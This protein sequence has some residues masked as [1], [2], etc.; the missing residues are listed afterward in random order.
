MKR[1]SVKTKLTAGILAGLACTATSVCFAQDFRA[2][3]IWKRET[4]TH[5]YGGLADQ[6]ADQGIEVSTSVTEVYQE[7]LDSGLIDQRTGH[8]SG[9]YDLELTFDLEHLLGI[10][11]GTLY[12]HG[13]GSW[14]RNDL[15]TAAVGS[16]SGINAD[17][18]GNRDLDLTE[19]WY[20]HAFHDGT[21]RVRF[22]KLDITG[23]FECRGCA[24]SFD[25]SAY[26]NDETAQFLSGSLV[27]NLTIPFPD[28]GLGIVLYWNPTETWYASIGAADARADARETGL[29]TTFDGPNSEFFYVA[30]TGWTPRLASAKGQLQGAYRMGVWNEPRAKGYTGSA[31]MYKDDVG[32]YL[33]CDQMLI[34][35]T[36]D[37]DDSQGL[38]GF[39]RYGS[40]S[41]RRNDIKTFWSA[42]LQ[43][44]G[45]WTGRDDDVWALGTSQAVFSDLA[46]GT[47]S[48]DNETVLEM[49]YS[50]QVAPWLSITPDIQYVRHPGGDQSIANTYIAGIR[51]QMAF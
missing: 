17:A 44:Q 51:A 12:V 27:N 26:A 36:N 19:V 42:G 35:E 6:L 32:F 9:S 30:E 2:R 50:A 3:S 15:D 28:K 43:Y 13:E 24:V 47:Y 31:Q 22:G 33:S 10:R 49:Y 38:G 18:A 4:L 11:H 48:A 25:G 8:H 21:L 29:N 16:V 23:G 46:S 34:K 14:P 1:Q 7:V 41:A 5:G 20:E 40:A 39:F 45:A 37:S